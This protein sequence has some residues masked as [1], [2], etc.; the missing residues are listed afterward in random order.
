VQKNRNIET[1]LMPLGFNSSTTLSKPWGMD[2][3]LF[4]FSPVSHAFTLDMA[5]RGVKIY[6]TNGSGK[7]SGFA[8]VIATSYLDHG[9][10]GL[11]LCAKGDDDELK[12]WT[13]MCNE[14]GR[15]KSLIHFGPKNKEHKL[16]F[17]ILEFIRTLSEVKDDQQYNLV[18]FLKM[19][20]TDLQAGNLSQSDSFW[21]NV[22]DQFL[23]H[24]LTLT[25]SANPDQALTFEKL[26][27]VF[28][29]VQKKPEDI[30]GIVID[31]KTK[32]LK[33]AT[34][35]FTKEFPA[36]N[37]KTRSVIIA[38]VS[39][40]L[41]TFTTGILKDLF[42]VEGN[43]DPRWAFGGAI[44]VINITTSEHQSLG[45][46]ANMVWKYA[47]QKACLAR[48]M[49]KNIMRP[50]FLWADE[51][52]EFIHPDDVK[53]QATARSIRCASVYLTQ[54]IAGIRFGLGSTTHAADA[55][56]ALDSN[57]VTKI[58]HQNIDA[59]TNK[60][61]S[62]SIGTK[63]E[64]LVST[65]TKGF[66]SE[67]VSKSVSYRLVPVSLPEAFIGLKSGGPKHRKLVEAIVFSPGSGL[68]FDFINLGTK[69]WHK[70]TV[71]QGKYD[72]FRKKSEEKLDVNYKNFMDLFSTDENKRYI[73]I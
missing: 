27:K 68:F 70:I 6:G 46:L 21:D 45:R 25:F 60:Y 1:A 13:S 39:S 12:N 66:M 32:D 43:V 50:V 30:N 69:D 35:F 54:N 71:T 37:E 2:D 5:F 48:K 57:L 17:N 11:V 22:S 18:K 28:K 15:S 31:L 38:A 41:H 10:G 58:F 20:A 7:T 14:V 44:F 51:A 23:F 59:E 52:Q 63:K 36:I 65:S 34:D 42:G 29:V 56:K 73:F 49:E 9:F 8:R 16:S 61:A 47:F 67:E 72:Y 64:K 26:E 40:I 62:D 24:L 33:K 3:K 55:I 4:K 19:C 53:F